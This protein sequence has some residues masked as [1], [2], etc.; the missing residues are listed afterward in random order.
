MKISATGERRFNQLICTNLATPSGF[1]RNQLEP[2]NSN[3]SR[4]FWT[5]LVFV[6]E[7]AEVLVGDVLYRLMHGTEH[8]FARLYCLL[9]HA[10]FPLLNYCCSSTF[11]SH[12]KIHRS[13]V[14]ANSHR[15]HQLWNWFSSLYMNS[16]LEKFPSITQIDCELL[17]HVNRTYRKEQKIEF[18]LINITWR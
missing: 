12:D 7:A 2:R 13:L 3:S 6:E 18:N 17:E 1:S 8:L 9:I 11:S 14:F 10:L 16:M 4:I 5:D 15:L